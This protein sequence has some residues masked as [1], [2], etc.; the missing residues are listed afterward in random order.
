MNYDVIVDAAIM[1]YGESRAEPASAHAEWKFPDYGCDISTD[2]YLNHPQRFGTL[3]KLHGSLTWLY[4]GTCH[5]L[6][7]GASEA[8]PFVKA[9]KSL[10]G[11]GHKLESF[12][13]GAGSK[14]Q[15]CGTQLRALLIAPSHLKNY[16]NPH[17]ANVWYRAEQLLRT[18]NRAVLHVLSDTDN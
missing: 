3:L 5:R 4:C 10:V 7:I 11:A 15:T 17:L 9:L 13:L 14:C 8:R 18:A 12:Y 16:R 2:V 1:F 6:E